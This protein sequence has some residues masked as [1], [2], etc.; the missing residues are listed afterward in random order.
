MF[1]FLNLEPPSSPQIYSVNITASSITPCWVSPSNAGGRPQDL[2]YNIYIQKII[3]Q[4]SLCPE[5]VNNAIYYT[6]AGGGA[7][8]STI[9][10]LES[11]LYAVY[12]VAANKATF[13]PNT[14]CNITVI[15]GRYLAIV[16]QV[17]NQTQ[18]CASNAE[19]STTSK[20]V[21]V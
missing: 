4:G 18:L 2:Y 21:C 13:D 3:A 16:A 8:C 6:G 7:T 11:S 17:Q 12:V 9:G 5:K 20:C 15:D 19:T 10:G 14:V 1:F